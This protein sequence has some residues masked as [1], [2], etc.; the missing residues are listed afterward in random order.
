MACL[1]QWRTSHIIANTCYT[2]AIVQANEIR[3][4]TSSEITFN[5][6]LHRPRTLK[7]QLNSFTK[8]LYRTSSNTNKKSTAR[9]VPH[10]TAKHL[11]DIYLISTEFLSTS[12]YSDLLEKVRGRDSYRILIKIETLR[13]ALGQFYKDDIVVEAAGVRPLLAAAT[14]L[15]MEPLIQQCAAIMLETINI[16]TVLSYHEGAHNYGVMEVQKACRKWLQHNL[17][18]QVTEHPTTLRRISPELMH[19][20]LASPHLYVMQTE[21]SVYVMLKAWVFLCLH[22]WWEGGHETAFL[23]AH[24]F[25]R[26][27]SDPGCFLEQ[28]GKHLAPVF[29]ALRLVYLIYHHLDVEMLIADRSKPS[30]KVGPELMP[31]TWYFGRML[32]N[33]QFWHY[34]PASISEKTY[35]LSRAPFAWRFLAGSG[36]EFK[37]CPTYENL[38]LSESLTGKRRSLRVGAENHPSHL[39]KGVPLA[40][41]IIMYRIANTRTPERELSI[42]ETLQS[43]VLPVSATRK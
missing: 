3:N 15:Q 36:V 6:L 20:L 40:G 42:V 12:F 35:S 14:M 30:L 2:E 22:P 17:L 38:G 10:M 43:D 33:N 9:S 28:E 4:D 7:W 8:L 11:K 21:F 27:R 13:L 39:V 41:T 31:T 16:K 18:T 37:H 19:Q 29:S 1:F 5:A 25:F 32:K 26:N 24:K 23:E 34:G